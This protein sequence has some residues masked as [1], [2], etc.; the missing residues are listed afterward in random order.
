MPRFTTRAGFGLGRS[1]R[2][3]PNLRYRHQYLGPNGAPMLDTLGSMA[4]ILSNGVIYIAGGYN[5]FGWVDT[6]YA[7][8]IATNTWTTLESMPQVLNYPGSEPSMGGYTLLAATDGAVFLDT[9]YI[10]EIETHTWT[11]GAHLPQPLLS[12]AAPCLMMGVV[13]QSTYM[14]AD[15][16]QWDT[17]CNVTWIY[18]PETNTWSEDRI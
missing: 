4:T 14:A 7:Y 15:S 18:D 5:G 9:L 17:D 13:I 3:Y 8:D 11:E 16:V 1:N 2:H 10:Y 12:P 6:L